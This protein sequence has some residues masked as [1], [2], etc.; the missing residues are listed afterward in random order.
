MTT[1]VTSFT[2]NVN[3]RDDRKLEDYLNHGKMLL[4]Q[5]YDKV[6][7]MEPDLIPQLEEFCKGYPDVRNSF[8]PY[9][10]EQIYLYELRDKFPN[11][12]IVGNK[13][14]DTQAYFMIMNNKPEL[15][16]EAIKLNIYNHTNYVWIDFGIYHIFHD[17]EDLFNKSLESLLH[18]YPLIRAGSCWHPSNYYR[19][20]L[21]LSNVIWFFAGG[22]IGGNTEN[23][24]LFAELCRTKLL[25]IIEK[26]QTITWEVNVWYE[27]YKYN[28]HLFSLYQCDHN[29]T[30]ISNY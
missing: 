27:V 14:K 10:F 26:Y 21:T 20:E 12:K 8:I 19:E 7:F 23:I 18:S 2:A 11:H 1:F 30:L 6:I 24:P 5:K 13:G 3:N 15:L 22:I 9:K 17:N 16:L 4:K 25:E 29:N 28:P